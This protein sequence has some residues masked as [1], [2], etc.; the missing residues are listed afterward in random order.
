M[1]WGRG[2][3]EKEHVARAPTSRLAAGS[4]LATS[5]QDEDPLP[6]RS[7][8]R[9]IAPTRRKPNEHHFA[10]LG[11]SRDIEWRC[12]WRERG[13]GER[14]VPILEARLAAFVVVDADVTHR[15]SFA[16][17]RTRQL[18]ALRS[19][20]GVGFGQVVWRRREGDAHRFVP[21]RV[22]A[23][24]KP[25]QRLRNAGCALLRRVGHWTLE[26]CVDGLIEQSEPPF[27]VLRAERCARVRGFVRAQWVAFVAAFAEELPGPEVDELW[28]VNGPVDVRSVK[29]G[30]QEFVHR[31]VAIESDHKAFEVVAAGDVMTHLIESMRPTRRI[32]AFVPSA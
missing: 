24:E 7:R 13:T 21:G 26:M 4:G 28:N 12:R 29:D 10:N 11:G 1:T 25:P 5:R 18:C 20:A 6:G 9:G 32:A 31:G 2:V 30:A 8:V 16:C 23:F 17:I 22:L 27:V 14:D 3:L 15:S 19:V